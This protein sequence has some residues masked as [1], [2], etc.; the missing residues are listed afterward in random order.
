[1]LNRCNTVPQQHT[2]AY[3]R[4]VEVVCVSVSHPRQTTVVLTVVEKGH[5]FTPSFSV[6]TSFNRRETVFFVASSLFQTVFI[7]L[8][9]HCLWSTRLK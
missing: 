4:A 9:R 8:H 3:V 2:L 5:A 7:R 6:P 1:M